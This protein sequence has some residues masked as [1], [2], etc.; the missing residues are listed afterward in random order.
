[1][2]IPNTWQNRTKPEFPCVLEIL[3]YSRLVFMGKSEK[4]QWYLVCLKDEYCGAEWDERQ[5]SLHRSV[6]VPTLT[7]GHEL[8]VRS[9]R[10]WKW[11]NWVF[12]AEWLGFPSELGLPYTG[13]LGAQSRV[14]VPRFQEYTAVVWSVL[15]RRPRADPGHTEGTIAVFKTDH[16]IVFRECLVT[17][18]LS[19]QHFPQTIQS[20]QTIGR[21]ALCT[22]IRQQWAIEY[23]LHNWRHDKELQSS[24]NI[25]KVS[26]YNTFIIYSFT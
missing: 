25:R 10:T 20:V 4:I 16:F 8:W 6:Y 23:D 12:P 9:K 5:S 7:F 17:Q 3:E 18:M 19:T 2:N 21:N 14:A 1:M 26:D 22:F 15:W 13:V 24:R 11:P